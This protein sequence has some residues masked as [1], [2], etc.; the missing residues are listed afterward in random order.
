MFTD[1]T[2]KR[3]KEQNVSGPRRMKPHSSQ[4]GY[5]MSFSTGGLFINESVE[6]VRLHQSGEPWQETQIRA[7]E[8]GAT[9]LPKVA[10][11]RRTLRE[12]SNRVSCLTKEERFFLVFTD[13]GGAIHSVERIFD[14]LIVHLC[15]WHLSHID[16]LKTDQ[17]AEISLQAYQARE[18]NVVNG[19]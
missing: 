1:S 2:P 17:A 6:L 8:E 19:C 10:S 7:A 13:N 15:Y 16:N 5:R 9:S 18:R 12:I 11:N 14:I 4:H 3:N